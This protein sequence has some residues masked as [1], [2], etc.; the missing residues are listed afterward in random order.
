MR[1]PTLAVLAPLVALTVADKL[2]TTVICIP[3][4]CSY[5]NGWWYTAYGS[6][7]A[8][9]TDGCHGSDM[10]NVPGLNNWC[11][12]FAHNRGH[13]YFQNQAKR[14]L[15]VTEF[16][17][18]EYTPTQTTFRMTWDEIGCTW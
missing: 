6:Y 11:L 13:F 10:T 17:Q 12:D 9:G 2:V 16:V 5:I 7:W 4:S 14:C 18:T 8:I 15:Q 1:L 3:S